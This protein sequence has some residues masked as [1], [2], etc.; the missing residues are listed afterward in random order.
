[1]LRSFAENWRMLAHVLDVSSW[2]IC[3][4]ICW[5]ADMLIC[6]YADMLICWYADMLICWYAVNVT[7]RKNGVLF[8]NLECSINCLNTNFIACMYAYCQSCVLIILSHCFAILNT[9]YTP[10]PIQIANNKWCTVVINISS[11]SN[12][13]VVKR[14][15]TYTVMHSFEYM[16]NTTITLLHKIIRS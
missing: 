8:K 14:T 12:K 1:M 10:I 11:L 13:S 15:T 5:Y 3:M 4:L 2:A 7:C 9:T 16:Y 6:W